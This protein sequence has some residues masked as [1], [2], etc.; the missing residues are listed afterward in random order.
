MMSCDG[1]TAVVWCGAHMPDEAAGDCREE[2]G[3][4][5]GT[6]AAVN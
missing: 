4:V 1:V 5:R 6:A 2:P 3:P